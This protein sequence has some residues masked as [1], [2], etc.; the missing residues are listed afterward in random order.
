MGEVGHL[1][2]VGAR[3]GAG[4]STFAAVLARRLARTGAGGR[5]VVLVDL[6]PAGGGLDVLVGV[7]EQPGVRWPD[8]RGVRGAVPGDDLLELLPRWGR[9]HVLSAERTRPE[10]VG[11]E[12]TASVLA[13]LAEQAALVLDLPRAT[14]SSDAAVGLCA[15][16]LVLVPRDLT[17]VAGAQRVC[18]Q[19]AHPRTSL[20]V[21]GP[22]PGSVDPDRIGTVLGMPVIA[23][24]RPERALSTALERGVGPAGR[25]IERCADRTLARLA[26]QASTSA[27]PSRRTGWP[28]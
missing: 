23:R 14:P 11:A 12:A 22:A 20:V 24:M 18:A 9:V 4:A 27:E 1:G 13:G 21:R 25:R 16:L 15:A 8:L 19:L 6:D 7:E 17:G 10:P 5:P 3:G 28:R 26:A 2:V